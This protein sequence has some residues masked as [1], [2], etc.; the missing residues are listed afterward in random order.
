MA[1]EQAT[2]TQRSAVVM[3]INS[4]NLTLL[5]P[6][7]RRPT[8][9]FSPAIHLHERALEPYLNQPYAAVTRAL[10]LAGPDPLGSP[11]PGWSGRSTPAACL[12]DPTPGGRRFN[13]SHSRMCF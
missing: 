1:H 2:T 7:E 11:G 13:Q 10:A 4:L 6:G 8:G 9:P 12:V 3:E 5:L